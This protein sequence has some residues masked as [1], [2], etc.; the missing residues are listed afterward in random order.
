MADTEKMEFSGRPL[1]LFNHLWIHFSAKQIFLLCVN[2]YKTSDPSH[3]LFHGFK[4]DSD[5]FTLT[6]LLI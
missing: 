1:N 3:V 5:V 4:P 2:Q 6:T